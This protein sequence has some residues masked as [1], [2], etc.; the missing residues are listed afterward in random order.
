MTKTGSGTT[1]LAGANTYYGATHV[2]A[3]TLAVT[4]AAGSATGSGAVTVA[5]NAVLS[6]NG[7]IAPHQLLAAASFFDGAV[8]EVDSETGA[9]AGTLIPAYSGTATHPAGLAVG[10]DGNLYISSQGND[11][12]RDNAIYKYDLAAGNLTTFVDAPRSTPWRRPSATMCST[13]PACGSGRTATCTWPL[14]A[15]RGTPTS[16][17]PLAAWSGSTSRPAAA[18]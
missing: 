7:T 16:P 15:G 10:P 4:N 11:T 14:T 9:L 12:L 13:R 1:T 18:A 5:A 2:D 3:G 17:T 8:Y 6:G